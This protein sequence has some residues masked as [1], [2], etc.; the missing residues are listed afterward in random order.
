[1]IELDREYPHYGF[2]LHK[3]YSTPEHLAMLEKHGPCPVHRRSFAPVARLLGMTSGQQSL[4]PFDGD[5]RQLL[6]AAG[7]G[8]A[9]AHL[10][11]LGWTILCERYRCREGEIDL[12]AADVDTVVF[13][14]VKTL[15]GRASSPA[16][17]VHAK[18]RSRILA[19]AQSWVAE[20]GRDCECRFDVAAVR[21]L[22]EG[23]LTVEM[24]HDAFRPGE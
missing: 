15:R 19:A 14:E 13:V 11:S 18:K 16:E 21:L 6:G 8:V 12:I 23:R 10:R 24:L 2:A 9:A 3:G 17:S 7:E 1:M 22:P 4:L 20:Q 5:S